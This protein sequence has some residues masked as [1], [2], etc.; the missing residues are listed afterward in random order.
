MSVDVTSVYLDAG[1]GFIDEFTGTY[2]S[3]PPAL[4]APVLTGVVGQPGG[5]GPIEVQGTSE[6][7][8]PTG[9]TITL[10]SPGISIA[11]GGAVDSNGDFDATTF[12]LADGI[13]PITATESQGSLTSTPS[14]PLLVAVGA[15]AQ[16][17]LYYEQVLQR[18]GSSAE[19]NAWMT[20]E[21]SGQLTF[22]QILSD[23]V[24]SPE[25]V[26]FVD[27]IIRLYEAA[28]GRIPDQAGL[29]GWE[30]ALASGAI[31]EA[32]IAQAIVNS[33]EFL[34]D[35]GGTNQVT[36]A[37]VAGLYETVLGRPG[38][39]AEIN[40]WVNSGQTAAQILAGFSDS[41]EFIHDTQAQIVGLLTSAGQG[42]GVFDGRS[43][44]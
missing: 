11:G 30:N 9:D 37:F 28:L 10:S 25:A 29:Q 34:A 41:P 43:L 16:I 13:Y 22:S 19:V 2:V 8:D 27:P 15:T 1:A 17:E 14:A 12:N 35:H 21:T 33:S 36:A 7:T 5:N 20:A 24:N 26:Q 23:F 32:Q 40:S 4:P 3:I 44:G 31:T 42:L 38:S 6:V 39:A 18:T